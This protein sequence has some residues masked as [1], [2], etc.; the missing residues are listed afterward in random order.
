MACREILSAERIEPGRC[1]RRS[2]PPVYWTGDLDRHEL[3]RAVRFSLLHLLILP[4]AS[5][6]QRLTLSD[7]TVLRVSRTHRIEVVKALEKRSGA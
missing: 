3:L 5:G 1:G 7:G 6:D 4:L 2:I